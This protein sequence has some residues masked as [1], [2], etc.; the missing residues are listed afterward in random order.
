MIS[1]EQYAA[2]RRVP[3]I[4]WEDGENVY[5]PDLEEEL[6]DDEEISNDDIEMEDDRRD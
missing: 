2:G 5:H 1:Q 6:Y 3:F 4:D